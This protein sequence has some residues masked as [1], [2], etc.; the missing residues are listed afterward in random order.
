[1]AY[2]K[3]TWN[4]GDIVSSQ[5]LNH[6]EDGIANAGGVMVINDTN[7]TLDKTWQEIRDAMEANTF[8]V[9][10]KV[11]QELGKDY[12]HNSPVVEAVKNGLESPY[13]YIV[14]TTFNNQGSVEY[15]TDTPSGYPAHS[16]FG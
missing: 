5:K 2:T 10:K 15:K 6:M 12:V 13:T 4:T 3:N 1:M 8:C 7:G 11:A 14:N 16:D 9:V